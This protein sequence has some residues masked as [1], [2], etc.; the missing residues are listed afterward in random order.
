MAAETSLARAQD[1]RISLRRE[2]LRVENLSRVFSGFAAVSELSFHVEEGEIVGL[3][4]PNGAGKT[5]TFNLMTGFLKPS[6][7]HIFFQDSE[8]TGLAPHRLAQ[9]GMVRTFQHTRVFANL[10]VR[11]NVRV[12]SHMRQKGGVLRTLFGVGAL[13]AQT[14]HQHVDDVLDAVGL[15]PRQHHL[16]GDLAYGEQRVLEIALA[17]AASPKLLLLDEP[18]A[19][20]N[21]TESRDTMALIHTIR[22]HDITVLVIDH[23]MQTMA[24][25]CDRLVVMN[26]GVKLAEGAPA[27]V[28]QDPEVVQAYLGTG[29]AL[30]LP[31]PAEQGAGD[32]LVL[33]GVSVDYGPVRALRNLDLQVGKGE[34]V[35]L[36]GANGA[37]K[38]TALRAVSG[39][40]PVAE[41]R[42][43][44][45]G[46]DLV[47]R[48]PSARVRGGLAHCPEGRE[49]FP[50]MT[51]LENLELGV[52]VSGT[53]LNRSNKPA[54][55]P[56][57]RLAYV[58]NLFPR[59]Q[60]RT[61]QTA[62]SLSGGEQQMLA[63]GRALMSTPEVLLL[64]EP[65]LGL[66]PL[67]AREVA[68]ALVRLNASGLSMLLVE[69]N[70][71][72]ALSIAHRAYVLENGRVAL[73]G[74]AAEVREDDTVR[75]VYLGG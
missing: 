25:G 12:A 3:V 72:L 71:V 65:T 30:R 1:D 57:T 75:R 13:E 19:G 52:T 67:L 9:L 55:M 39:L 56:T 17:L 44:L 37:G 10:C 24:R 74:L 73:S 40:V 47:G 11:E 59:L 2:L 38:S 53:R 43:Q 64:D 6:S 41:G 31:E 36:V 23:H 26:H 32:V 4:G 50:Q 33:E 46:R 58:Y 16:A 29:E 27:T 42:I 62:G 14:L 5:T 61:H 66:A 7:G 21:E 54:D 34:I 28:T 70:A 69:Q 15:L 48:S 20:M 68:E 63:I 35:A 18:F 45:L 22:S 51:V 60:E 8:V 49:I